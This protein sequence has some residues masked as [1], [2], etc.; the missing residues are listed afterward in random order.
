MYE[1]KKILVE[2]AFEQ[3]KNE[4][5]KNGKSPRAAYINSLFE[6]KFGFAKNERTFVRYYTNLVEKNVD[7]DID[8]IT[9]D[10][11]SQY[12]GYDSYDDFC[13]MANFTEVNQSSAFTTVNVRVDDQCNDGK[14]HSNLIINITTAPI[15][16]LQEFLTKQSGLGIIG[17]LVVGSMFLGKNF[18]TVKDQ[19]SGN[20]HSQTARGI[21]GYPALKNEPLKQSTNTE[22]EKPAVTKNFQEKDTQQKAEIKE[23]YM[24]WNGERFIATAETNLGPTLKVIPVNA[25]KLKYFQ[26]ITRP[27]TIKETSINKIW[28]SKSNNRV[29]FFTADGENPENNKALRPLSPHM[30]NKYIRNY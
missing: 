5:S 19:D 28:Y 14:D 27:D 11:L 1:K 6:E 20:D 7:Q 24:Y 21:I 9:L 16:R 22:Q 26:K 10:Q 8:A 3:A 18:L 17:I 4:L 30:Y 13:K 2:K 15:L 12:I 25:Y 23:H 29:E